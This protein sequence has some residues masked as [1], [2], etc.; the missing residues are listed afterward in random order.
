MI[1]MNDKIYQMIFNEVS[2]FLPDDWSKLVVYLEHGEEAYSYSFYVKMDGN[3]V[4]CFDLA[5][6]EEKLFA[7][8]ARIEKYVSKERNKLEKCWSNMTMIV[9]NRGNMKTD[10]D[11][12]DLS[13]GNYQYKKAWKK[14]YLN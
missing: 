1:M 12:T 6:S 8:F 11:Y 2:D 10:F 9:D 5:V 3:Y 4:K 7:A 13:N 14:K